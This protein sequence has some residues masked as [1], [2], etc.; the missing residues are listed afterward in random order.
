MNDVKFTTAEEAAAWALFASAAIRFAA[1]YE[2][3]ADRASS[4]AAEIADALL[5]EYRRRDK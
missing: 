2:A 5:A 3:G 4:D 1:I